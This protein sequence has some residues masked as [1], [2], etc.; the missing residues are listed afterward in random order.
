MKP[1]AE[2]PFETKTEAMQK[3]KSHAAGT[4]AGSYVPPPQLLQSLITRGTDAQGNP[5]VSMPA[6]AFTKLLEAALNPG[7]DE[8]S[9]LTSN[10]DIRAGVDSGSI[11]SGLRHFAAYGFFEG[12]APLNCDFDSDWYIATYPDVERAIKSGQVRDAAHHFEVFGY[13]EGRVPSSSF[14]ATVGEW[15][16]LASAGSAAIDGGSTATKEKKPPGKSRS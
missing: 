13:A 2:K 6:D 5:I 7:F 4:D 10:S 14:Q 9:Y 16:R 1:N 3:A 11:P 12:R 15:H 8:V